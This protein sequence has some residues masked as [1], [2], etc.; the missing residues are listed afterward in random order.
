MKSV[1]KITL[2]IFLFISCSKDSEPVLSN[3]SKLL[4]FSLKEITESFNISSNKVETT[5][6][7]EIDLKRLT[8][9]FTT[10]P[11]AK[12]FIGNNIQTSGYTKN[13]FTASV[14]YTIQAEDGTKSTYL[15]TVNLKSKINTFEIVELN[16]IPFT[17]NDSAIT[18]TVPAGTNLKNLTAEFNITNN[19][20]L[21]IGA[22]PQV[23]GETKNNF[24]Q[25]ITYTIKD[26]LNTE[27]QYTVTITEAD[28]ILPVANAG[29]DKIAII[30]SGVANISVNLNGSASSDTEGAI[31]SF[32]W[33][34]GSTILGTTETLQVDLPLGTH[35]IDLTVTDST[36]A[37]ATD[38][39]SVEVRLQG[40]YLPVD[41]NA[42]SE[43]QTLFTNLASLANS[44]QFAFGQEFPLS[45]Q[46]N[47][48]SY[49]LN[50]SDAKDVTGDHPAVYGIDPHYML[51]KT[52]AERQ[53][54]IDEAKHAYDN[55]SV[56]TFDFHQ[57]SRSDHEIYFDDITTASDKSLMY[58]VVNNLN[59][60]RDWF[61]SELDDVIDI[62]N[63]DLGF[64]VVFRLF[65]EMDG[66]WFW[67]GTRA[68]NHNPELYINLFRL[69][70]DYIKE[71]SDLVLFG[72]TPNQKLNNSYYP[73]DTY[74]D[75]VGID[76]YS[77]IS[78][79]L[80]TNLIELSNFAYDH[81][82]VAVLAETGKQNYVNESPTFWTSNILKSIE[83]GGSEIRIAWALAW[84]NAPWHSSQNNLFIPNS[85]SSNAI[86]NDFINFY[87]STSTL[88]QQDMATLNMYN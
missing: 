15:V 21:F 24:E 26:N 84:F 20:T 81:G 25:P 46:L 78:S 54:H 27:K 72:W 56:V 66:D 65:H 43:T 16:N 41:S 57:Q 10:S 18:A 22:I 35:N 83:D 23:S 73:G 64:P 7:D 38:T 52:P 51:Y 8:A 3:E 86:K 53:L 30:K 85:E 69:A 12:V 39:V 37:T 60:S 40:V 28:N 55:G 77:P 19:S 70:T 79:S 33:K 62:I 13:N 6:N 87:S 48:V 80:K 5:L 4:S 76:V 31:A 49:D 59:G 67:W 50:T 68:T 61:Y 74:V 29:S 11:K 9:V 32:E 63:N 58:D 2:L 42:T 71:R 88:F 36:G 34:L 75:V 45:Y 14:T 82:K 17:I 1:L 44:S 47:S